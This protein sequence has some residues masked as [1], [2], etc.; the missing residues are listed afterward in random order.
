MSTK[1]K[2]LLLLSLIL[3]AATLQ[4]QNTSPVQTDSVQTNNYHYQIITINNR[5][6]YDIFHHNKRIIHQPHI[7]AVSGNTGFINK[8]EAERTACFVIDKLKKGIIP[9]SVSQQELRMLG[10]HF[11]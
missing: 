7:P 5:Y 8:A 10:I 4:A 9:P 11:K 1:M 6:G 2:H 3:A